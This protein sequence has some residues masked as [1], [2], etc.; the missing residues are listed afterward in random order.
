MLFAYNVTDM[1]N[2]C[3]VAKGWLIVSL[4]LVKFHVQSHVGFDQFYLR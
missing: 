4:K 3:E 2:A 1:F